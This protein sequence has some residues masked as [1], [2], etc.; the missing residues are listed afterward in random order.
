[1]HP[2]TE[3]NPHGAGRE[4]A[5]IDWAKVDELAALH[6][7]LEQIAAVVGVG[8]TT[9]ARRSLLDRGCDLGQILA[10]KHANSNANLLRQ[11]ADHSERWGP[12][13]IFLLKNRLGYTDT[14]TV[15]SEHTEVRRIEIAVVSRPEL[16][17]GQVVDGQARVLAA[18][19]PDWTEQ[20]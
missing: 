9:L 15:V 7:P 6:L 4:P 20:V 2:I 19:A 14:R 5:T 12:M 8:S 3:R 1:M 13:T 18:P 17:A 11:A 10:Q 16:Q